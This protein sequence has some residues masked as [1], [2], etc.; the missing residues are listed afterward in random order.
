MGDINE[1]ILSQKIWSLISKLG[2]QELITDRHILMGPATTRSK[3]SF[4]KFTEY[5]DNKESPSAKEATLTFTSY[6][7]RTTYWCGSIY[8]AQLNLETI[9]LITDL[10]QQEDSEY[11]TR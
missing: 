10:Q 9:P 11:T 8:H 3:K 2:L 7:N 1:Y 5:E 6:P 4:K